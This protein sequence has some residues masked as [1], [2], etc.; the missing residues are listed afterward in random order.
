MK[1]DVTWDGDIRLMEVFN[2]IVLETDEGE[3]MA[4]CMR[5]G[6]FEITVKDTCTKGDED[7]YRTYTVREGVVRPIDRE[8]QK[9]G[10]KTSLR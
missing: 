1:I 4:V 2:E 5:D 10:T 8:A 3:K 7:H 6:G 9:E